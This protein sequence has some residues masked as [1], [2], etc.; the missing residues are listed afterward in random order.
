MVEYE[1]ETLPAYDGIAETWFENTAAMR[2][3]AKAPE[4]QAM[5]EDEKNFVSGERRFVITQ[6]TRFL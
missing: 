6:E 1:K 5:R 4:Y 3:A 2:Q